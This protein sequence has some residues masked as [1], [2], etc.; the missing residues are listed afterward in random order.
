MFCSN[1]GTELV[2]GASFCSNC[3]TRVAQE[4]APFQSTAQFPSVDENQ[5]AASAQSMENAGAYGQGN[6]SEAE[7]TI[8]SGNCTWVKSP[9][10]AQNGKGILTNKR[11]IYKKGMLGNLD[12]SV[13]NFLSGSKADFEIPLDQ[14]AGVR[15]GRHGVVKNLILQTKSGQEYSCFFYDREGW[16]MEFQKLLGRF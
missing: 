14:L 16:L 3:G 5:A 12:S 7:F 15:E 13:Y 10:A 6:N 4:A 8:K 2:S 1:C 11:F 9:I